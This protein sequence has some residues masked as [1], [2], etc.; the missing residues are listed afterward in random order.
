MT[1]VAQGSPWIR[2][3]H[4]PAHPGAAPVLVVLP[5]AGGSASFYFPLSRD[6]AAHAEVLTVQYPGRQERLGEPIP[7]TVAGLADGVERA[8]APWR[9]RPLVLFGHSMGAVLA[10]ELTRRLEAAGEGPSGLIVSGRRSP[11]IHRDEDVHTQGDDA[12]LARVHALSGTD[13]GLL[14]DPEFRAMI[15]PALRS[16]YRAIETW[17]HEPGPLLRTP[18]SVLC[19]ESDPRASVAE[20]M[21]WR[22]LTGAAFTFR[23][24]PGGHFYLAGQPQHEAVVRAV[25]EDLAAFTAA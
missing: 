22:E 6:L 14:A 1:A 17:R 4:P 5:H 18:V 19:G 3:F 20:A 25:A 13:A 23:G 7:D 16:D 24:F 11:L 2:R 21:G 15:L 12:L 10:Y 9:G 8:L